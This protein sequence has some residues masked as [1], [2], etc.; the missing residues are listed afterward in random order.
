MS[1]LL[2]E[3][4]QYKY[5]AAHHRI[6]YA[7]LNKNHGRQRLP[8]TDGNGTRNRG[9]LSS[10]LTAEVIKRC[11]LG[12]NVGFSVYVILVEHQVFTVCMAPLHLI[13]R[14]L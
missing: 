9:I 1:N 3:T 5:R 12:A 14:K 10:R 11:A 6:D 4:S 8:K 13:H 2:P 7:A